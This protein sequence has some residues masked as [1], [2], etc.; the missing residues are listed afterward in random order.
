MARGLVGSR[1]RYP[2]RCSVSRWLCTVEGDVRPTASPISRTDG[3]KPRTC[4]CVTMNSRI[5]RWRSVSSSSFAVMALLRTGVWET[6]PNGHVFGKHLFGAS[7]DTEHPF[8]L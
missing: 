1:G 2:R 4:C 6:V 3:G 5:D 7:L 8:W